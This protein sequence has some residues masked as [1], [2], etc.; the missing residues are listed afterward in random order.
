VAYTNRHLI[1]V[2]VAMLA[3]LFA[4]TVLLGSIHQQVRNARTES[5]RRHGRTLAAQNQLAAA[6]EEY[7]AALSLEPD[8]PHARRA[9]ALTLLS[10]DRLSEAESYLRDLLKEAPTDGALHRALARIH[11]ARGRETDAR[12][13]YQRAI[14]GEWPPDGT[15][16]IDTRFELI[17]YLARLNAR[18]EV[19]AELVR[20]KA[21]LPPAR[22]AAARRVADLLVAAGAPDLAL[23]TLGAAA[24][25][26]PKDVELLAH[27]S[28]VQADRGRYDEARATLRHALALDPARR[29]LAGRLT[30]I[31]RVLALDPTLPRLRLVTRTRR[32]RLV[33]AAVVE[34]TRAC[35]PDVPATGDDARRRAATR[36]RRPA[37]ADAEAAEQ[38]LALAARLWT[39]APAC[40]D[41]GP[42]GRA[43][44]QVLQRIEAA[45]EL[46]S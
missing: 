15:E 3:V 11:A 25:T 12:A 21:E 36:L 16:R 45:S 24:M 20:L 8:E 4:A 13:A 26:A 34:H 9:L 17:E 39:A 43:I 29:E 30:V 10:L 28:D 6:A 41:S 1:T 31:D 14:Y 23:D 35:S 22:T 42:E 37:R 32:A 38:D 46:P 5:H 2:V 18:E 7:R 33:L 27:L 19:L 40:H 44:A